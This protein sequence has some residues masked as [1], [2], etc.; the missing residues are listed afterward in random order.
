M[1]TKKRVNEKFEVVVN[2]VGMVILL[3]L[4]LLVTVGDIVRIVR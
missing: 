3:G 1:I 2:N 4:L